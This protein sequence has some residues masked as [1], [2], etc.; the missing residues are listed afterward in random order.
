MSLGFLDEKGKVEFP[1]AMG[2]KEFRNKLVEI[3]PK[4]RNEC[5]LLMKADKS[6]ILEYLN[7]APSYYNPEEI[8]YSNLGQGKLY[9]RFATVAEVMY[10]DNEIEKLKTDEKSEEK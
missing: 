5:Y 4:L 3:Y 8:Y 7:I 1:F 10:L 9:I 2:V 6:N